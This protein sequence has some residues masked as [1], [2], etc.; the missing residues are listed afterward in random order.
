MPDLGSE[1]LHVLRSRGPV[2][3]RDLLGLLPESYASSASRTEINALLYG[4]LRHQVFKDSDHRWHVSQVDQIVERRDVGDQSD[5]LTLTVGIA[6]QMLLTRRLQQTARALLVGTSHSEPPPLPV[7]SRALA[8]LDGFSDRNIEVVRER[9]LPSR[10]ARDSLSQLARRHSMSPSLLFMVETQIRRVLQDKISGLFPGVSFMMAHEATTKKP[11]TD[12]LLL[13]DAPW[14]LL[15][16]RNTDNRRWL[17][18]LLVLRHHGLEVI[19]DMVSPIQIDAIP[20]RGFR[21][22]GSTDLEN[23]LVLLTKVLEGLNDREQQV[24]QCRTFADQPQTLDELGRDFGVTRERIRQIENTALAKIEWASRQAGVFDPMGGAAVVTE[25]AFERNFTPK[26][27]GTPEE[28]RL[29]RIAI[30]W[31]QKTSELVTRDGFVARKSTWKALDAQIAK[32]KQ[33]RRTPI[34]IVLRRF[35]DVIPDIDQEFLINLLL[36]SD[37]RVTSDGSVEVPIRGTGALVRAAF[38]DT[39]SP[40]G[41]EQICEITRLTRSQVRGV[42]Q[43]KEAFSWVGNGV[44]APVDWGLPE[45]SGTENA[46]VDA[47]TARGGTATITDV[48]DEVINKFGCTTNSCQIYIGSSPRLSREG[49][50]VA[51]ADETPRP[52]AEGNPKRQSR[53]YSD[54]SGGVVWAVDVT[55]ELQR[56]SGHYVPG[57]VASRFGLHTFSEE[58]LDAPG[59]QIRLFWNTQLPQISSLRPLAEA[60]DAR[61][62]DRLLLRM[63]RQGVHFWDL[64]RHGAAAETPELMVGYQGPG[65]STLTAIASA[66]WG[67]ELDLL[68]E[69]LWDRKERAVLGVLHLPKTDPRGRALDVK[70]V[71]LLI[72]DSGLSRAKLCRAA[73]VAETKLNGVP[74]TDGLVALSSVESTLV[75]RQITQLLGIPRREITEMLFPRLGDYLGAEAAD[76]D[77]LDLLF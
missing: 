6:Y 73:G 46:I 61:L 31:I 66:C 25:V 18:F 33:S 71:D 37:L 4:A 75:V 70:V 40:M 54:C 64:C 41:A 63:P 9:I 26:E 21:S 65:E 76:V 2:K 30:R 19:G 17:S 1:I 53:V 10:A 13:V 57:A 45:Y 67:V 62:G 11:L 48:I 52:A 8:I 68:E 32:L 3:A 12:V 29:A 44:Y 56:G 20:G 7:W 35:R 38:D 47:V 77:D 42:L 23:A 22:D 36:D 15:Q 59:G 55:P 16:N 34:G 60:L 28:Q 51:L 27:T 14:S 39:D 69:F 58:W 49:E 5:R 74:G 24:L 72:S 50:Q 43:R